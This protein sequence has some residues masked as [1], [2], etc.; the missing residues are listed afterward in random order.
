MVI[1]L[2]RAAVRTSIGYGEKGKGAVTRLYSAT[3][4][5]N[6]LDQRGH[7]LTQYI[8]NRLSRLCSIDL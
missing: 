2:G 8:R 6:Y 1:G 7:S 5:L 3:Q 4:K